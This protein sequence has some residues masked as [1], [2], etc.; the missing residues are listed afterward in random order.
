VFAFFLA[1]LVAALA[2][3]VYTGLT[4][5]RYMRAQ[6]AA[7]TETLSRQAVS[8]AALVDGEELAALREPGDVGKPEYAALKERLAA[9]AD[10]M[11]V[12]YVYYLRIDPEGRLRYIID[13][14]YDEESRV[15]LD[16]PAV[17]L[18]EEEGVDRAWFHGET[19]CL[20]VGVY[21]EGWY[22]IASAYSPVR[23]RDG[24]IEAVAGVDVDDRVLR[25]ANARLTLFLSLQVAALLILSSCGLVSILTSRTAARRAEAATL[26]KSEFLTL[27]SHEIRTPVAV[28]VH[29]ADLACREFGTPAAIRSVERVSN[30]G[31]GLAAI[32]EDVFDISKDERDGVDLRPFRYSTADLVSETV[33][34]ASLLIEGR[35]VEIEPSMSGYIPAALY[36]DGIRV[37]QILLNLLHN[38]L[39]HT[40]RGRV[41]LKVSALPAAAPAGAGGTGTTPAGGA[42]APARATRLPAPLVDGP[43]A[44]S[45]AAPTGGAGDGTYAGCMEEF[46]LIFRVEDAGAVFL[47]DGPKRIAGDRS[48]AGP[49]A[50]N[51][52]LGLPIARRL[53]RSMGGD[54]T[55]E[56]DHGKGSAFTAEIIQ[57]VADPGPAGPLAGDAAGPVGPA[58]RRWAGEPCFTA[59]EADILVVDDLTSNLI[60][61]EGILSP[62]LARVTTASGGADAVRALERHDYDLVLLDHMMP[63]MDGVETVQV[64]RAMDGCRLASLPVVAFTANAVAGMREFFIES[65]FD[66]FLAKPLDEAE[67]ERVLARWLPASKKVPVPPRPACQ[68]PPPPSADGRD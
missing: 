34:F 5:S 63:G 20:G 53:A 58:A 56:S 3:S 32:V 60:V 51:P 16:T 42:A 41:R 47:S 14:D 49:G 43:P 68:A 61:A 35:P 11:G 9:F 10:R 46:R 6:V 44:G 27:I 67:L 22:G 7:F 38:A 31:A 39:R 45:G 65:G 28:V 18:E 62:Y 40:P 8:V 50:G 23:R 24:G 48:R 21:V 26:A 66:D 52:S 59:P 25:D 30:A 29:L 19:V 2:L 17:D 57:R 33:S 54:V 55:A 13:N 12:L 64:I 15:G 37:K 4:F 36:G 1:S